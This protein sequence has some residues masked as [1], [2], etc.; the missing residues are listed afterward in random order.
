MQ[1]SSD[2]LSLGILVLVIL[3][4]SLGYSLRESLRS[5]RRRPNADQPK[6]YQDEDGV[7]SEETQKAF[8]VRYQ[9]F[10]LVVVTAATFSISLA[11]L[12]LAFIH[13][14]AFLKPTCIAFACS[15]RTVFVN[16]FMSHDNRLEIDDNSGPSCIHSS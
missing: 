9:N 1:H 8:S 6:L 14:W 10:L 4:F 3:V 16:F 11:E 13:S 12:V 15:V 2:L 7:A 5:R